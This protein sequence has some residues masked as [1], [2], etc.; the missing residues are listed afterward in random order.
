MF[1]KIFIIILFER[2]H[3][4]WMNNCCNTLGVNHNIRGSTGC[5]KKISG[6][7][8]CLNIYIFRTAQEEW[9]RISVAWNMCPWSHCLWGLFTIYIVMVYL[10]FLLFYLQASVSYMYLHVPF[11]TIEYIQ[12][13]CYRLK[14][15]IIH[16]TIT[17]NLN[18]TWALKFD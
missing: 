16:V 15:G 12:C 17:T 11:Y 9:K 2:T 5:I 8:D 3:Y 13:I 10:C 14:Q 1:E 7:T 18:K 6:I 4:S